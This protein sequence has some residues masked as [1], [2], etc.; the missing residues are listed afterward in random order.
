[1]AEA[2]SSPPLAG[3]YGQ[4]VDVDRVHPVTV[5]CQECE[6]ELAADSPERRLEL[7]CDDELLAYCEACWE[8]EF[9]DWS[10]LP[11]CVSFLVHPRS[12]RLPGPRAPQT[13][14]GGFSCGWFY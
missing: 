5:T 13:R 7:T 10:V 9:G 8:R 11:C 3:R 4:M 1:M 6:V 12:L 2:A 14:A